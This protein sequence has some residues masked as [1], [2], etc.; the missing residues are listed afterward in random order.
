MERYNDESESGVT[1]AHVITTATPLLLASAVLARNSV[2]GRR[3]ALDDRTDR[4]RDP[5]P[6]RAT[7]TVS[8]RCEAVRNGIRPLAQARV[9]IAGARDG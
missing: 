5:V 9:I 2:A 1:L 3:E 4:G 6:R 7:R 8:Q